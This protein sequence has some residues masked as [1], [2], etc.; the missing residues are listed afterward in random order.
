MTPHFK[1]KQFKSNAIKILGNH[2]IMLVILCL[3]ASFLGIKYT[4]PSTHYGQV[5]YASQIKSNIGKEE[6]RKQL[7]KDFDTTLNNLLKGN[8]KDVE[9]IVTDDARKTHNKNINYY[10][11]QIGFQRGVF[12]DLANRLSGSNILVVVYKNLSGVISSHGFMIALVILASLFILF[13]WIFVRNIYSVIMTRMIM[14][15]RIYTKVPASRAG[16]LIRTKT[17]LNTSITMLLY[18]IIYSLWWLTIIGGIYK[19]YVYFAVPYIVSEKPNTNI[20]DAIN[21][22][23]NMMKGHKFELFKLELSFWGWHFL[24]LF[25]LGLSGLLFSHPYEEV[26]MA[27]YFFY[28]RECA[29]ENNIELIEILDD[30]Y[31]YEIPSKELVMDTYEDIINKIQTKPAKEI[32]DYKGFRKILASWFG[33]VLRYTSKEDAYRKR[34]SDELEIK[35]YKAVLKNQEY[36]S[37]L[38]SLVYKKKKIKVQKYQYLRHY[39]LVT[40]VLMFFIFSFVGWA[41]EVSIHLVE[42]GVF[43][44]RGT[45]L[46]PWL[47]IYGFGGILV[48]VFLYR[49]R[50]KPELQ[51]I[52]TMVVAGIVEYFTSWYLEIAHNGMKWWDYSNYFLNLNGRICAEGLLVFGIGGVCVVYFIAPLLDNK[53]RKIPFKIQVILAVVLMIIFMTDVV[54]SAKHPNSGKGITDYSIVR[55]IDRRC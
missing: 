46:G 17:W 40:I 19:S 36:P 23:R 30:K 54:Y 10:G 15:S 12:A 7:K 45:T 47:P 8:F 41:W 5:K 22:S 55:T 49:L 28:V 43:V 35:S 26:T 38:S 9:K 13:V 4:T 34:K 27:N 53:L 24:N 14:E 32:N 50:K 6:S 31:L 44:N 33:I 39:S 51:F 18:N 37:R 48:L 29:I 2:Y 16:Y 11:L 21:L 25:T 20:K 3:V 42:D 1:R 52:A